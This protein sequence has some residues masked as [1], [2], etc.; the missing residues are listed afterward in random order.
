MHKCHV[1]IPVRLEKINLVIT[2]ESFF[3]HTLTP[4]ESIMNLA[5]I[6]IKICVKKEEGLRFGITPEGF[7]Y[8]RMTG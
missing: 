4:L 2:T 5:T 3:R 8:I 7:R 6:M 1:V